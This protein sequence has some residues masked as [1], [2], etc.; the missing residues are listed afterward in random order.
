VLAPSG[1]DE[2]DAVA[3]ITAARVKARQEAGLSVGA[4][5]KESEAALAASK[6]REGAARM[7][8]YAT[9]AWFLALTA[10]VWY[11][12][13]WVPVPALP[14]GESEEETKTKTKTMEHA[15]L[16]DQVLVFSNPVAPGS[17]AASVAQNTI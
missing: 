5:L 13:W 1:V 12:L 7:A 8:V 2:C 16:R 10:A 14:S 3:G 4:E 15:A 11:A 17:G 9:A 6:T